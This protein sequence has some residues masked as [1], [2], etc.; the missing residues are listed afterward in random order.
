MMRDTEHFLGLRGVPCRSDQSLPISCTA[1]GRAPL[2]FAPMK[3][4]L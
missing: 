2:I 4:N 1:Y 3:P